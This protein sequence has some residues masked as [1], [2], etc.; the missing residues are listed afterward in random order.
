MDSKKIFTELSPLRLFF[1]AALPG[2]ISMAAMSMYSIVEGAFIGQYLGGAAFAA[3][4]LAMP[5]IMINFAISDLIAVGSSVQIS[6]ALGRK[7]EK[8][9]NGLFS[10]SL[11]MIILSAIL[12]GALLFFSAP[13]LFRLMGAEGETARLA[14]DYLR[15]YALFSPVCTAMFAVDNYLRICGFIRGSMFLNVFSSVLTIGLLILFISVMDMDITGA[16]LASSLAMVVCV[17][18]AFIPFVLKKTQ[19]RFARPDLSFA[20]VK[21]IIACGLPTFLNNIAGRLASIVMNIALLALGG[22][23]AVSAYGVLMYASDFVMPF[24][25]GMNDSLQPA[26]G[27]NWGAGDKSRVRAIA[28]CVFAASGILSVVATVLLFIFSKQA[29]SVFVDA[30]E[31]ELLNLASGALKLHCISILFRWFSFCAQCFYSAIER[32]LPASVLSVASALVFPLLTLAI[33][34]PVGL[35]GLWLNTVGVAVFTGILAFFMLKKTWR[36]MKQEEKALKE[37]NV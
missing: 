20:S 9:A 24:L 1:T 15:V 3:Q 2:M 31:V 16:A 21:N 5:F 6:I 35:N 17:V 27:F 23:L 8:R 26:I 10:V 11:L 32:P 36:G 19:L 4:G 22:D 28:K 18:I 7:E 14:V 25:Y 30:E 34:W 12:M 37:T 33:L 13:A 29:A